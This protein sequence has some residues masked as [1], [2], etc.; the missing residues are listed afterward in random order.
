MNWLNL[1][2]TTLDSGEFL[3]ATPAQRATWLC[4]LRY[5]AG[6]ENGGRIP[7]AKSWTSRKWEQIARVTLREVSTACDLWAW[8]GGDLVV[9]F[10]PADKEQE[11][12]ERRE[13]ARVNG[14]KGGRPK[15]PPAASSAGEPASEPMSEPTSEPIANQDPE[16]EGER[17]RKEKGNT[18]RPPAGECRHREPEPSTDNPDEPHVLPRHWRQIPRGE[19]KNHRVHANNRVMQRIGN[20]FGR[21]PETLWTLAEGIALSQLDPPRDDLDLLERYYLAPLGRQEDYRRR[22]LIT[23]LN[24]WHG[25]LDRARIWEVEGG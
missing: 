10:Y 24:N 15:N 11:V 23:L 1:N 8:E 19:R 7:A 12:R 3:G 16:P 20:W 6:Q 17:E 9:T 22:D 14:A 18:P 21:K 4:L 13:R 2:V 5:C 25:E